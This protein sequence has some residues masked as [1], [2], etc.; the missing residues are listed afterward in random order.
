MNSK[1]IFF[2]LLGVLVLIFGLIIAAT[3]TGNIMLQKQ[4]GKL[5]QLKVDE[6]VLEQQ[7]TQLLQAKKDVEKY[8][9]LNQTAKA[10]V[11]QDKDQARTVREI[12]NIA[13]QNGIK[14]KSIDF[15]ASSLGEAKPKT[16]APAESETATPK[17][18]APPVSQV[19]PVQGIQGVYALEVRI[20]SDGEVPYV[21]LIGLLEGLEKNRRTAHVS[22][23]DFDPSDNGQGIKFVITLN[24]YIKP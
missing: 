9:E 6:K 23:V 20:S 22:K 7:K 3:T 24:A 11:P 4:S 12:S 1:R 5:V 13:A 2:I 16:A 19:K 8:S 18:T 10:I 14:L 17:V 15:E 21:S